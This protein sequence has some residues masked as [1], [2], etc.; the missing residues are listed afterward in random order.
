[1][2]SYGKLLK[3]V[4]IVTTIPMVFAAGPLVGYGIGAWIDASFGTDP[5]GKILTAL[6]GFAASLKQV[7]AIIQRWIK[8]SEKD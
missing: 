4:G 7:V 5:W 3:Q 1:M 8:E 2:S 6:L